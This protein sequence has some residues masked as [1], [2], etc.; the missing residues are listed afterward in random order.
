MV[1]RKLVAVVMADVVGYSR[2]MERDESGTHSR[3]R[4]LRELI[5]PKAAALGGRLVKTAGDGF[6]L[7]FGS[8]TAALRWAVDVQRVLAARNTAVDNDAR[9]Q[10]RIGINLGDIIVEGDD[11]LGDGVNVA[12]RLEAIAEPGGICVAAAVWEQVRE[13]L[14]V[15]FVDGG[16]EYV[17][18]IS[19]PV[20][21]F[22][23]SVGEGSGARK[24][25]PTWRLWWLRRRGAMAAHLGTVERVV[26]DEDEAVEPEVQLGGE[27]PQALRFPAPADPPGSA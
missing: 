11:I 24:P 10:L 13:D 12:A 17:K 5:V 25:Q 26:V 19:K 6:L 14:G 21:V 8:A 20:H 15:S 3:L 2:L 7:E 16:E 22:R 9:L 18:N 4:E 27:R 23:V 1:D